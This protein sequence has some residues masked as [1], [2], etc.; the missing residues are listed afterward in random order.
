MWLRYRHTF[1]YGSDDDWKWRELGD[2]DSPEQLKS[3]VDD[4]LSELAT[5]YDWSE[6]YRGVEYEVAELPPR[7][8]LE[9]YIQSDRERIKGYEARIARYTNLLDHV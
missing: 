8:V 9:K 6:H 2:A 1:S 7:V 5:K 3:L 4:E